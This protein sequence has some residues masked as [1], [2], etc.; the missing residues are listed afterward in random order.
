V[1]LGKL[2]KII[3]ADPFDSM[4]EESSRVMSIRLIVFLVS[5]ITIKCSRRCNEV[6]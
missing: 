4:F 3:N 6:Y 1:I 2:S 5:F